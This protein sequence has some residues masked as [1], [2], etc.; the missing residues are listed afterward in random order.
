MAVGGVAIDVVADGTG[1][2]PSLERVLA[3]YRNESIDVRVNVDADTGARARFTAAGRAAGNAFQ[4]GFERAVDLRRVGRLLGGLGR[5]AGL[6]ALALS[7]ASAAAALVQLAAA[8]AP[9]VGILAAIPAAAGV[10]AAG[11]ATLRVALSGVG[12][13]FGAAISGDAEKFAEAMESLSPAAQEA[14]Q[15]V[16]ALA[17]AFAA[18]RESVQDAF[19]EGLADTITDVAGALMG[20]L[21]EGMTASASAMGQ[22]VQSL[23]EVA[24]SAAGVEFVERSFAGLTTFVDNLQDPLANLFEAF[25]NVGNAVLEA[26]GPTLG[27]GIGGAIDRFAD[28]LN[29]AAESGQAVAWVENALMVFSA[30]GDV[31]SGIAGIFGAIGEAA[32]ESGGNLLG[33]FGN[34]LAEI[35]AVLRSDVGQ[36]FLVNLF[37]ALNAIGSALGSL[38]GEILAALAPLGPVITDIVQ[39]LGPALETV[40]QALGEGIA[41]IADSGALQALAG[42][43]A[44]IL[45]AVSPLLPV[46]GELV[47]IAG[48]LF[49]GLVEA[50][51]PV[52]AALTNLLVSVLEP[53]L[54]IFETL[55]GILVEIITPIFA[56]LSEVIN[57]LTPV[58]V[59][60]YSTLAEALIPAIEEIGQVIVDELVPPVVELIGILA[61]NLIPV[62]TALAPIFADAL[63]FGI[64]V[65]V[66]VITFLIPIIG[67]LIEF[68]GVLINVIGGLIGWLVDAGSAMWDV[69]TAIYEGI[70]TAFDWLVGQIENIGEWFDQIGDWIDDVVGWFAD[71]PG[72]II[73][74]IG[75]LAGVIGDAIGGALDEA[76][77]WI[78]FADGGVITSPTFAKLGEDSKPEAVIPL[79]RP[80]RAM[81]IMQQTG[82]DQM[83]LGSSGQRETVRNTTININGGDEARVRRIVREEMAG[84]L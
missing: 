52:L 80:A 65:V 79:T 61:D 49:A 25:L 66:E 72:R 75:D 77:S 44:S 36:E 7:A 41:A 84:M 40:V 21:R 5:V 28:F 60:F 50:V 70:G 29:A 78:G 63:A 27:E 81:E 3:R 73:E 46:L 64:G 67:S 9:T 74:A 76:G 11:I 71:L 10:A 62:I 23:G 15:A 20:P 6:G 68:I 39:T 34:A 51:A 31:L 2:G 58:F 82:L 83:V 18:L 12:D 32:R 37:D 22:L 54:P 45:E 14:A 69:A 43:F 42:A 17:P 56:A 35:E 19:F 8:A 24:A 16:R 55:A 47:G 30:L 33:V 57:E 1:F 26:F 59:E 53:M 38:I 48:N 13:A 4:R